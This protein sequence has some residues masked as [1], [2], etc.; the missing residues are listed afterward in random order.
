MFAVP[1][2]PDKL[3]LLKWQKRGIVTHWLDAV[4]AGVDCGDDPFLCWL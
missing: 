3:F 4:C 1:H 2:F